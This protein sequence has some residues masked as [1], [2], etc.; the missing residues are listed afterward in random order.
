MMRASAKGPIFP[1][2]V[3]IRDVTRK[4]SDA[5]KEIGYPLII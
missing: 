2:T 1:A 4:R 5:A 3:A